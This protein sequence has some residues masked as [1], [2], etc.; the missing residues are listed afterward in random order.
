MLVRVKCVYVCA[1]ARV[2]VCVRE[3]PGSFYIHV[4]TNYLFRQGVAYRSDGYWPII[5]PIFGTDDRIW[6]F[7]FANFSFFLFFFHFPFLSASV[8]FIL[9]LQRVATM[10]VFCCSQQNFY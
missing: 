7:V 3:A 8:F 5:R 4:H 9:L 1:R 6:T 2:Y 10:H